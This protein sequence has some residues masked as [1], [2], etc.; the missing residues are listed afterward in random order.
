MS[1]TTVMALFVVLRIVVT[2]VQV[3]FYYAWFGKVWLGTRISARRVLVCVL[4][5]IVATSLRTF[6]LGSDVLG[7]S[8]LAV[9]MTSFGF[10]LWRPARGWRFALCLFACLLSEIMLEYIVNYLYFLITPTAIRTL[11]LGYTQVIATDPTTLPLQFS[12]LGAAFFITLFIPYTIRYRSKREVITVRSWPY[13]L[14]I[15]LLFS[16]MIALVTATTYVFNELL[17]QNAENNIVDLSFQFRSWT[18]FLPALLVTLFA[19]ELAQQ[20]MLYARNRTLINKNQAY[21]NILD[22]TREFRHNIAN[23]IY[24]F[25]GV[26]LTENIGD[27]K[28]YYANLARRCVLNN[29]ENADALNHVSEPALTALLLRKLDEARE[30][31]IP[32]YLS[33]NGDFSFSGM[34]DA[35]L[36][37]VLGVLLDNALEAARGSESPRVD[38]TLYSDEAYDS[39]LIANTY[40][41]GSDL[42]FLSGAPVSSKAGHQATG[43][44]SVKRLLKRVPEVCLNQYLRGRYVESNLCHYKQTA[45]QANG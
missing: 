30:A 8:A 45:G 17:F 14:R 44:V 18:F 28:S 11:D 10:I 15:A 4:I 43:L 13:W 32:L 7:V 29:N 33:A 25:E 31:E 3:V 27:I 2:C 20:Y 37:E 26:I 39:V 5:N 24:G 9:A 35:Q 23:L 21:Q 38:V 42:A 16:I 1:E 41:E 12:L 6:R 19:L 34:Q 22:S 40:A 36:V